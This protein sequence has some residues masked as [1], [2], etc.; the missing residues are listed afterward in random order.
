MQ[1]D[2]TLLPFKDYAKAKKLMWNPS[3]LDYTQDRADWGNMTDRE[4]DFLGRAMLLFLG[5][6][7]FVT[8]DLAPLL[9]ALRHDGGGHLEE[10]MFLTTQLFEESKHVEF[11]ADVL[12]QVLGELPD[13]ASVSGEN[14]RNLFEVELAQALGN[15]LT[16]HSRAAQV[17]AVVTYHI[18][19][20][21]VLAETAYY[22][23]FTA[24]KERGLMPGL[25]QGLELVQRDEARHMA[26]GLHL[27][28]RI[29]SEDPTLWESMEARINKLL[30]LAQGIFMD[31]L[32][33]YLPDVPFGV[34]LN[35]L[36]TYAG[37]QYMARLGVLERAKAPS[38]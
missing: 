23:F 1:L 34:D 26:F 16:D 4:R 14:Y 15:L 25:I 35:D 21:G 22:G 6:E 13:L 7:I 28:S 24:L 19:I 32:G 30:P 36:V 11:F 20:E 29:V 17:D 33:D 8:H 12:G 10:E 5:G 3:D 9:I 31:L 18:I 38:V 37:K 2:R 27:L